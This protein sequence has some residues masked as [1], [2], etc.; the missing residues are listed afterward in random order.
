MVLHHV[1]IHG[2]NAAVAGAHAVGAVASAVHKALEELTPAK[3]DVI[4]LSILAMLALI[5]ATVKYALRSTPDITYMEFMGYQDV[6][7][8]ASALAVQAAAQE[9]DSMP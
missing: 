4:A 3:I 2:A 9:D 6:D 8:L 7:P 1:I 5:A